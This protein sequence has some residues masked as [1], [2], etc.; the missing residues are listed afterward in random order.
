M[1]TTVS[2]TTTTTTTTTSSMKTSA[3]ASIIG[4]IGAGSGIDTNALTESLVSISHQV[5]SQKLLS[6][7]STIETQ[8]SDYGKLRSSLA[9][10][11]TSAASLGSADTF[12]AKSVSIPTTTQFSIT[13]L[14]SN[15]VAGNYN[16]QVQQVAQAQSLVGGQSFASANEVIGKGTLTIRLG[17]WAG[18]APESFTVNEKKSSGVITIDESNNTLAGLRDAINEAGLGVTATIINDGGGYKLMLSASTGQK[19]EIEITVDEAA[20][21]P[22]LSAFNFNETT[23]NLIQQ[24]DGRDAKIS[25]NGLIVSRENNHVTDVIDGLEFDVFSAN[26]N[27]TVSISIT[28]D[29]GAAEQAIRDFVAAYNTLVAD[30]NKLIGFDSELEANG[31]LKSDPLAKNLLQ[32]LR[33]TIATPITGSSDLFSTLG[34]IG[35]RTKADGTLEINEKVEE[36]NTNFRAAIDKHFD[37]VKDLFIPK[38][39]SNNSSVEVAK[40]SA[41]TKAGVYDVQITQQPEK[42]TLSAGSF[43]TPFD[44]TGKDYS[45]EFSLDGVATSTIQ[46]TG[47]YATGEALASAIQAAVNSDTNVRAGMSSVSIKFENN[48]F[49]FSS[50]SYGASSRVGFTAVSQDFAADYGFTEGLGAAGVD[51]RGTINGVSGFGFGNV[52]LGNYGSD[53]DGLSLVVQPG[54]TQATVSFSRGLAGTINNLIGNY[55]ASNGLIAAREET[56]GKDIEK[57]G[58]QQ[59]ALTRRTDAYRARLQAQ[60]SAMESIVRTLTNTGSLLDGINDR[61]PFTSKN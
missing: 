49:L 26:L 25:V 19:N 45:F 43:A 52:L 48:Q 46:L 20:G 11:Q 16:L 40:Y 12:N 3:G 2:G 37:A 34:A 39:T 8:I 44:S 56:L 58:D 9:S 6:R 51:I 14:N 29:K 22:G 5:D 61:L 1:N 32:M 33:S 13:A 57:V 23:K 42:G 60:F 47:T 18:A 30:V 50:D 21:S 53:A 27:E 4:A 24:Q 41:L 31:S 35:V 36:V 55:L 10:F 17:E 28:A 7:K 38:A 59:D 15:A 54:V